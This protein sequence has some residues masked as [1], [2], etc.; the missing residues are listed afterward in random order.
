M[1][2]RAE[3]TGEESSWHLIR[4]IPFRTYNHEPKVR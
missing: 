3:N 2:L 1:R 4:Q